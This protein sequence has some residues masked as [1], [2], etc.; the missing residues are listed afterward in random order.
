[1]GKRHREEKK[2]GVGSKTQED[3]R[4]S[5]GPGGAQNRKKETGMGQVRFSSHEET[6]EPKKM[7][8]VPEVQRGKRKKGP[9]ETLKKKKENRKGHSFH[10]DLSMRKS[11]KNRGEKKRKRVNFSGQGRHKS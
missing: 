7:R 1:M 10:I 3:L 11:K 8:K 2:G 4:S 6:R 9:V 5:H